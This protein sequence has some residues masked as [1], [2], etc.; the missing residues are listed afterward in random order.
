MAG[1]GRTRASLAG[2]LF[3]T[4]LLALSWRAGLPSALAQSP[5]PLGP[6]PTLAPLIEAVT[7]AVVNIAVISRSPTADNPLLRDPFFRR[8][9]NL[10]DA[11]PRPELSAGSGVIV[12]ARRGLI[13]TNHHV[14]ERASE[15]VVTLKDRRSFRAR[16]VGSDPDTDIA[17]LQVEAEGLTALPFG[18]S[19]ALRVGDY[20]VAIGNPFGLGQTVTSGI[21][22]ALG[23]TGINA[24][25]YEDFIQTDASINPGNSGGALVDLRGRLI[26]INTAI[27]GPAGGNV[28]IGF[29]VP[30]NMARAVMN[31]LAEHGEVRR[32]RLGIGV[33]DLT[34]DLAQAMGLARM[35]EGAVVTQVE[36]GSPAAEAGLVTGDVVLRF[37]GRPLR[38]AT[39]LRNR[40]GL[41]PVGRSVT[42]GLVREGR[43]MEVTLR[44]ARPEPASVRFDAAL[45][46]LAGAAFRDLDPTLPV[47]G[48][49]EGVLVSA[50]EPGSPAW[51]RGLR[52]GDVIL[53]V[54]RESVRSVEEL[55]TRIAASSGTLVLNLL[56]GNSALLLVIRS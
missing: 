18:D 56:R 27:I 37:D 28:G 2:W 4:V 8:F 14:I 43:Q 55:R 36:P 51:S 47:Y 53:A 41:A 15:A 20:V 23:R 6:P 34:P 46:Q 48:K 13:L 21:V 38:S 10:P 26:G 1:F 3:L 12:D 54:N 5:A 19:D 7:P 44:I 9:F 30:A 39:D 50:C 31:Q 45:P 29:A 22:S 52:T 42:L 40:I 33:Q 16:L 24:D 49:V 32:G 17:L 25:G 11:A 35:T